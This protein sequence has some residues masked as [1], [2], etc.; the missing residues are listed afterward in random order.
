MVGRKRVLSST[1][2]SYSKLESIF[3]H[4][5]SPGGIWTFSQSGLHTYVTLWFH[6]ELSNLEIMSNCS[7]LLKTKT[8]NYECQ[9]SL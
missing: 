6:S 1:D 8:K 5:P 7:N 4:N 3:T 9:A 2:T